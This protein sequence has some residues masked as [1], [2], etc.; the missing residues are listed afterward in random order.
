MK[1]N[2][3][4]KIRK[5]ETLH[6]RLDPLTADI[7]RR[8]AERN[9]RGNLSEA[10]RAL[11]GRAANLEAVHMVMEDGTARMSVQAP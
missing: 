5:T 1:T 6:L 3:H 11:L 9:H 2:T 7:I 10:T 4:G 8:L